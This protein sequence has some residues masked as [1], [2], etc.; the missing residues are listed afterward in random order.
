MTFD[1]RDVDTSDDLEPTRTDHIRALRAGGKFE[2]LSTMFGAAW[3]MASIDISQ[4]LDV[5]G[6]TSGSDL[7]TS[8]PGADQTFTKFNAEL[9]RLQ[10]LTSNV[11]V[12]GAVHGQISNNP[13]W[14]SE[15]FGIGGM[16]YGRG[17]DPSEIVGDQ[18]YAGKVELQWQKPVNVQF[19]NDWQLYSF[20]DAGTVWN[21]DATTSALKRDSVAST[22]AGFRGSL[23]TGTD[24][25]ALLAFPL[26]RAVA[27]QGDTDARFFMGL[28]QKF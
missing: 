8:R 11:N 1:V 23:R 15:Q 7:N 17:Y 19:L 13:L 26:T 6:S 4:G 25:N 21:H 24:I 22:G 14:T 28:S 16:D 12:L 18:G 2:Y 20:Y 5:L 10:R 27:T 3:N 9:Q